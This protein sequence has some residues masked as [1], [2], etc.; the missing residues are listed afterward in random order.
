MC[1]I[2]IHPFCGCQYPCLG[3][4]LYISILIV[5]FVLLVVGWNRNSFSK[6]RHDT[7]DSS[8]MQLYVSYTYIEIDI[9][10]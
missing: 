4:A 9:H 7:E 10:A 8:H 3:F 1:Y 5:P 6:C 2:Y